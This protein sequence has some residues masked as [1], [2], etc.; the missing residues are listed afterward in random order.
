MS[1]HLH[2]STDLAVF[3]IGLIDLIKDVI[4]DLIKVSRPCAEVS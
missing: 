3:T 1:G 2:G 4:K